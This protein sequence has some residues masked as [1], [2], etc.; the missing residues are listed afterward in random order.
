MSQ[1]VPVRQADD[2]VASA[3]LFHEPK[4]LSVLALP[5]LDIGNRREVTR[6]Y[7][8]TV[9][10][11]VAAE[12]P[13]LPP[14]RMAM[15]RVTIGEWVISAAVWHRVR[16]QPGW[17]I[18]IRVVPQGGAL[19]NILSVVV[20]IAA[21]ALGQFYVG[22]LL[23]GSLGLSAAAAG[24]FATAALGFAGQLLLQALIPIKTPQ[25]ESNSPT[26]DVEGWTNVVNKNGPVADL[27]GR[28]R[29]APPSLASSFTET[30]GDERWITGLFGGYG[31]LEIDVDSIKIGDTPITDLEEDEY[32]LEIREGY[33]DDEPLSLYPTQVSEVQVGISLQ[34]RDDDDKY[35]PVTRVAPPDAEELSV[36]ISFPGGLLDTDD[37]GNEEEQSVTITIEYRLAGTSTWVFLQD[38]NGNDFHRIF[39]KTRNPIHRGFRW[40]PAV[41]GQY[42]LR[43]KRTSGENSKASQE[44]VW[45]CVRA[46]RPEY[47][48]N[49]PHPMAM[50]CAKVKATRLTNGQLKELNFVA[51]RVCQDWDAATETWIERAT[52][53]PA[54]LRRWT[55]Q[56]PANPKPLADAEI[57]LA[58]L[59]DWHEWCADLGLEYNRIHDYDAS[60]EEVAQDVCRAGRATPQNYGTQET[61]CIDRQQTEIVSHIGP[62]N[63]W[64]IKG[65]VQSID[66]PDAWRIPFRDASNLWE[67]HERIVPRPGLVGSPQRIEELNADGITDPAQ[68]WYYGRRRFLELEYRAETWTASMDIENL[69][70]VRGNLVKLSLF[71]GQTSARVVSVTGRYVAIDELVE[72]DE[73]VDYGIRFRLRDGSSVTWIVTTVGGETRGLS[74]VSISNRYAIDSDPGYRPTDD[75]WLPEGRGYIDDDRYDGDLA[76]FGPLNGET[77]DAIVKDVEN[78]ED[79]SAVVTLM[80]AAPEIDAFLATDTP[81]AWDGR[82]GAEVEIDM[83]APS[84][85]I[86]VSV[87]SGEVAR[88]ETDDPND[89]PPIRAIVTATGATLVT[90]YE[91]QHRLQGS[92]TWSP[93]PAIGYAYAGTVEIEGYAKDDIV[94]MQARSVGQTGLVS[95][96]GATTT[97]TVGAEDPTALL[98][99]LNVEVS[100]NDDE[101]SITWLNPNEQR[102][103]GVRVYS[104]PIGTAYEDL[105]AADILATVYSAPNA[106]PPAVV[107][108][109]G[110]GD[111]VYYLTTF[112]NDA[113]AEPASVE[114][115][116]LGPQKITNGGFDADTSYT[117]GPGWTISGGTANHAAGTA[118]NFFQTISLVAG[119][120]YRGEITITS[121]TSGTVRPVLAGGATTVLGPVISAVGTYEFD[122]TA[123]SG[124]DRIQFIASSDGAYS[125]DN[126]SL[127][128]VSP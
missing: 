70:I 34:A 33:P 15:V 85:P 78:G 49:F 110:Y 68:I 24:A 12:F 48:L 118:S 101:A 10:E 59:A 63:A 99:V 126:L 60:I 105:T 117:K 93:T 35:Y 121:Y 95:A 66:P 13:G 91:I 76:F 39:G 80:P 47:P 69:I 107:D 116:L 50:I 45:N 58:Y 51:Q 26:Y 125:M 106:S 36:D 41:R 86:I 30:I 1:L 32:E 42:E 103:V 38:G 109:A 62:R 115:T 81:P 5:T 71:D 102:M 40:T 100:I 2:G 21:I 74:L 7:G 17:T 25:G 124:N 89:Y 92:S 94:E 56:G 96:W 113:E 84:T 111:R 53:S 23:A 9:A 3:A 64:D 114:A 27:M 88:R 75:D 83:V 55:L 120:T 112:S 46:H 14:E 6:P 8:M 108:T 44:T 19:R 29:W 104:A 31:P 119:V 87:R 37:E 43:L 82:V 79:F 11:M 67:E 65:S 54:S 28:H 16:P 97:V 20:S 123:T 127:R 18:V 4:T 98:S 77:V 22:P 72:M 128:Q 57:D 73:G 122:L 61:V 90:A 52:S